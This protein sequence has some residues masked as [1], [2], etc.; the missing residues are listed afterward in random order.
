MSVL[1]SKS[2]YKAVEAVLKSA[3]SCVNKT[4]FWQEVHKHYDI[5]TE[6][7]NE[8]YLSATDRVKLA[9]KTLTIT[10]YDPRKDKYSEI[11]NM[12]RTEFTT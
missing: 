10:G 5:G 1:H 9:E 11:T 8:Y 6:G 12:S 3:Q 2:A 4:K 7:I